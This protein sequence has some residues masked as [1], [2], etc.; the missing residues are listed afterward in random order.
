MID[1]ALITDDE[2]FRR[3]VT[4]LLRGTENAD[5]L[6]YE[7]SQSAARFPR[8]SVADV[9]A[10]NPQVAFVDLGES[11]TG[12]RVLEVLS[13]NAPD[14]LLIVAGPSLPA[15]TLLKVMRAG[16]TEYLPRPFSAEDTS[17]A[18][19]RVKR[20]VTGTRNEDAVT[21][22][23]VTT[24]FSPK[25]GVG[26]TTLAVNLAV[27][28]HEQTGE[29]TI[30]L[31]L[32][33]SLGT[34]ALTMGLQPRYSY[35]DV[36]QNFH[37]L[38]EELFRSFLE[39][40]E[41]G[42]KVLASPPR[43][44]DPGGPTMDEV[45]GLLR[46]CRKHFAFVVVDA[47]HTLTNAAD[48]ALMEADHKLWVSTPELPTLRNLKRTLELVG[49]H[50]KQ[51]GKTPNRL[52][53]N[54]YADGLGM[55]QDEVKKGLGLHV[56]LVIERDAN[57]VTESINMGQPAV[58]MRRSAFRRSIDDLTVRVAGR[59]RV[60]VRRGGL[61]QSLLKPFRSSSPTAKKE[62]DR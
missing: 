35:L 18:F 47:G 5:R 39:T 38:D 46:L 30:L 10:A 16:A 53:L 22:G 23:E 9:L 36:I 50:G 15:E 1:C 8:D 24:L 13:Q 54:Q 59:S 19:Q 31:D 14:L 33:P 3:H 51:N 45:M 2:N 44:E 29:S 25:G 52:I 60:A 49:T 55:S 7:A 62:G 11:T 21:R 42:V 43:T 41:T 34:A 40:H 37:R 20:R 26:V 28:L 12:L 61:L 56:D 57:L 48:V 32:S 27:S 6:V 17:Q 58:L 4:G